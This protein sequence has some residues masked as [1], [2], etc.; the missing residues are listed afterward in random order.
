[1]PAS[2]PSTEPESK[3]R[4]MSS[5]PES[6]RGFSRPSTIHLRRSTDKKLYVQRT[7]NAN[8]DARTFVIHIAQVVKEKQANPEGHQADIAEHHEKLLGYLD[9]LKPDARPEDR[10]LH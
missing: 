8:T 7:I 3:R 6:F 1:M 9:S 5:E 2:L 10:P 4:S